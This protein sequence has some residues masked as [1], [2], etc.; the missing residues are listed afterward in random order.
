VEIGSALEDTPEVLL[1]SFLAVVFLAA[2]G[3]AG[4]AVGFAAQSIIRDYFYGFY[5]I[6]EDWYRIGEVATTAG[7]TGVVEG[8]GLRRTVLRDIDGTMHVIPNSNIVLASNMTRDW[9]RVN[10]NVSVAY[11]ENLNNVIRVINEVGQEMKHDPVWGE[12]L[13]TAPEVARVDNLGDNGI[14][15]KILADTRPMQQW[16][17]MGELRKRLKDRFDQEGIE[18]PWPHTKV[19]FGNNLQGKGALN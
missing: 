8:M 19:Y 14:E 13:L 11:K 15:M 4:L 7:I 5:M 17:L 12:D 18:I 10:L 1:R 3:L 9:A 2:V 6:M 16:A